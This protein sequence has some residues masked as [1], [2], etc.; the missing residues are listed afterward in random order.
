LAA[1]RD[2]AENKKAL[3]IQGFFAELTGLEPA[4][5]CVTGRRSNQTELQLLERVVK[6]G[7]GRF[8]SKNFFLFFLIRNRIAISLFVADVISSGMDQVTIVD[9]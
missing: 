1:P 6:V 4:T 3:K 2:S 9:F 8:I 5:S 7:N